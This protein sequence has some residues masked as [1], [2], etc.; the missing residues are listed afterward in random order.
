MFHARLID[1]SRV[2]RS[3]VQKAVVVN[4]VFC[5]P[6]GQPKKRV[7]SKKIA[8]V[9]ELFGSKKNVGVP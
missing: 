2:I 4:V 5:G 8:A 9:A 7:E 6:P 1:T 3:T